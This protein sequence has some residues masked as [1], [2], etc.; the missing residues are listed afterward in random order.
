PALTLQIDPNYFVAFKSPALTVL[1][2]GSGPGFFRASYLG[3]PAV[4]EMFGVEKLRGLDHNELQ[5]P[6]LA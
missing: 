4:L 1:R 2:Y 3:P 6:A 5:R